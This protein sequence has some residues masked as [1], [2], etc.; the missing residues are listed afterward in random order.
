MREYVPVD[1]HVSHLKGL[2]A[3]GLPVEIATRIWET[4]ILW[5]ICMHKD[6]IYKVDDMWTD[7]SDD[8]D[9]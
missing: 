1:V 4:K 7:S 6:D 5:L 2:I 9:V 3:Q 8:D